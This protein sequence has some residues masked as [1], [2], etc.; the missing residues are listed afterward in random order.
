[1]AQSKQDSVFG[2]SPADGT[3]LSPPSFGPFDGLA[4]SA[5]RPA[6]VIPQPAL[7]RVDVG[8]VVYEDPAQRDERDQLMRLFGGEGEAPPPR[9]RPLPR[10]V[11]R[12]PGF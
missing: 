10:R 9:K 8:G 3:R 7:E 2:S 6:T 12:K 5:P 1:M 11:V 4:T